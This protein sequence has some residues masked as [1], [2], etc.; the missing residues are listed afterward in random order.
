MEND[1]ARGWGP[2]APEP[3]RTLRYYLAVAAVAIVVVPPVA[4]FGF[5]AFVLLVYGW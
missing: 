5:I 2:P 3:P 4:L 1:V